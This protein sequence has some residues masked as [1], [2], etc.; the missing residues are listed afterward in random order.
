ML[1]PEGLFREVRNRRLLF[2]IILSQKCTQVSHKPVLNQ[3]NLFARI[4]AKTG[5]F[6]S[7]RANKIAYTAKVA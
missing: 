6:A 5:I 3:A 2:S 7:S 4:E 1:D